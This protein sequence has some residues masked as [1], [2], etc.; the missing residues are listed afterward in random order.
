MKGSSIAGKFWPKIHQP[1]P[2][3]PRESRKL[4][5][6]LTSSFRRQLDQEHPPPS[7]DRDANAHHRST[8]PESSVQATNRHIQNILDNPLFRVVPP[9]PGNSHVPSIRRRPHT[10]S[11]VGFDEAAASGSV[12]LGFITRFLRYQLQCQLAKSGNIRDSMKAS[13]VGSKVSS[14]WWST[15]SKTR[16]NMFVFGPTMIDLAKFMVAEGLQDMIVQW[17]KMILEHDVG[18]HDGQLSKD[19]AWRAFNRLVICFMSAERQYGGGLISA[20]ERYAQAFELFLSMDK[21]PPDAPLHKYMYS[22]R[23]QLVAWILE[24]ERSQLKE[25][26]VP[27]YDSCMA[28]TTSTWSTSQFQHLLS[29]SFRLYHPAHPDPW[30]LVDL[31]RDLLPGKVDSWRENRRHIFIKSGLEAIHVLIEQGSTKDASY[32]G[33]YVQ[34][35]LQKTDSTRNPSALCDEEDHLLDRLEMNPT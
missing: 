24:S 14:W 22:P 10:F 35:V 31:A 8:N 26:P 34:L 3:T 15:D 1:L 5:T 19:A 2:R 16:I 23:S 33:D 12:T 4:L 30:P 7:S 29:S 18:G 32:L 25:I 21:M 9:N 28:P 11:I 27:L 17:L 13:K 20:M 6:A